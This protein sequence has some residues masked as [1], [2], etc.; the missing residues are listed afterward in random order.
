[1]LA[2]GIGAIADDALDAR[3]RCGEYLAAG[4]AAAY[5]PGDA[6]G[7]P[8]YVVSQGALHPSLHVV[9]AL[10]CD[11]SGA[12]LVRFDAGAGQLIRA[13]RPAARLPGA[14]RRRDGGHRR[15]R[16]VGRADRRGVAALTVRRGG[17]LRGSRWSFRPCANGSRSPR[18]VRI[19]AA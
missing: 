14:E 8:D 11:M 19:C 18:S 10:A 16:R 13:Q 17:G 4:G 5:L 2:L 12:A 1:M 9:Y 7:V 3:A 15:D 6:N